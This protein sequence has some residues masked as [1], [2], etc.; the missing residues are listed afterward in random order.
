MSLCCKSSPGGFLRER[1]GVDIRSA[2][3]APA[4]R[5]GAAR[6]ECPN[7]DVLGAGGARTGWL[8]AKRKKGLPTDTVT[9]R[10]V[11]VSLPK[12]STTFTAMM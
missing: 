3:A 6:W 8:F 2:P 5:S 4:P 12:M 10:S 9:G 1:A 11:I 7:L